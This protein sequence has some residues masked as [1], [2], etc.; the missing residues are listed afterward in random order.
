MTTSTLIERIQQFNQGRDPQLVQL[1]YE[2]MHESPFAFFRGTCHLFYEDWSSSSKLNAAPQ[3]WLCGDLHLEN[4]G[5][6]K[7]DNRLTYFDINDFDES[8][9]AACTLDLARLLTSIFLLTLE[10]KANNQDPKSLCDYF[11]DTYTA[12]LTEGKALWVER[13][14]AVGIVKTLLDTQAHL[15]RRDFLDKR[16]VVVNDEG[17]RKIRLRDKKSL[18]VSVEQKAEI[19]TGM[20][21]FALQQKEPNFFKVL[22]VASRVTGTGSLG[23]ERYM[24]LVQGKGSPNDNYL[25][26]LKKERESCLQAYLSFSQPEWNSQAER[27]ISVQ[28]RMQAVSPTLLHQ[29]KIKGK[30]YIMREYQP[31]EDK[32]D[33][34]SHNQ[35]LKLDKLMITLGQVVAWAQL[36]SSGR[37]GSAIADE[38][39]NFGQHQGWRND[40]IDYAQNYAQAVNIYFQAFHQDFKKLIPPSTTAHS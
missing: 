14:I 24:I 12:A 6:Y 25:L 37:Q 19:T 33:L 32:L 28:Q 39:I 22:D 3:T 29:V 15:K 11:L 10:T 2:K 38:L 23:L 5:S 26:D 31:T 16:T 34:S 21:E 17:K 18:P 20:N 7:G 13:E 8:V 40:L 9:L 4:F 1:K 30:S 35:E 27:A 36:R